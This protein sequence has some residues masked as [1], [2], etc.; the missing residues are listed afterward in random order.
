[1]ADDKKKVKKT[2]KEAEAAPAAAAA[3]AAEAPK[4]ASTRESKKAQKSNS[5][6]L[7]MFTQNQ[8][9]EFKEAFLMMDVDKDGILSK[10]DLKA[11]GDTYGR[12]LADSE[13]EIMVKEASGPI[14][15]TQLLTLFA[16]RMSGSSDEDEVVINAYNSFDENGKIDSAKLRVALMTFG[17]K[18]TAAEVDDAFGQLSIDGSGGIDTQKL[19]TMLTAAEED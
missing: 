13:L 11:T 3:P 4:R 5:N 6:I 18:F 15:F 2:K 14:N 1:M 8:T 12:Q 19:I 7:S 9:A 10:S 16:N 17:E